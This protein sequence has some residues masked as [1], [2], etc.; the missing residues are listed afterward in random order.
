MGLPTS[1]AVSALRERLTTLQELESLRQEQARRTARR[2]TT[3][4]FPDSGPLRRELYVKH[5]EFFA[6]GAKHR[7][8]LMLA[9]NRVKHLRSPAQR[10]A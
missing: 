6:A 3:T 7:E 10:L 8:R 4:Y 9:A 1:N 2:K 5:C